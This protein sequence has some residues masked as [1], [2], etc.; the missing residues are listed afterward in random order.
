MTLIV[1]K[2]QNVHIPQLTKASGLLPTQKKNNKETASGPSC[3]LTCHLIYFIC[4]ILFVLFEKLNFLK[5]YHLLS[6]LH[7][8]MY[9]FSKLPLNKF[10]K[11]L[12]Y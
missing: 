6:C 8:K 7:F 10:I 11:K 4:P 12:N 2:T 3:K 5:E 1:L 9:K